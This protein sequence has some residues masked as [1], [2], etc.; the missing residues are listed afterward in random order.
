VL[1]GAGTFSREAAVMGTPS[2]SFF[3]GK[4]FLGVDKEMF[5]EGMVFFSRV[6]KEIVEYLKSSRKTGLDKAKSFAVQQELFK[7][8]ERIL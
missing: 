2:V 4:T 6:P 5:A 8:I 1:T 3:S 7:L